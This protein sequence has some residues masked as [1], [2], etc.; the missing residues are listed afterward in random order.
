MQICPVTCGT[1]PDGGTDTTGNSDEGKE[2][3]VDYEVAF[4]S[5]A[6]RTEKLQDSE[7]RN[8]F[9]DSE[10]LTSVFKAKMREFGV[11]DD[12]KFEGATH[13]FDMSRLYTRGPS[14]EEEDDA[15][16]TED[17]SD[18]DALFSGG[19]FVGGIALGMSL[20]AIVGGF[21]W[22]KRSRGG[23]K[24]KSPK[25]KTKSS[26]N[27]FGLHG[28]E[29]E[30]T[31]ITISNKKT[32]NPAFGHSKKVVTTAKKKK[33]KSQKAKAQKPGTA[34]AGK[35]DLEVHTDAYGRRY[36]FNAKTNETKWLADDTSPS[37][38]NALSTSADAAKTQAAGEGKEKEKVEVLSDAQGRRYTY[39]HKSGESSWLND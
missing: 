36:T 7:V 9:T 28:G 16:A 20:C 13:D 22:M 11:S 18:A 21:V 2:C 15:D 17:T 30:L 27:S 19:T 23:I 31:E 39:N 1:C 34:N 14:E 6:D 4:Y 38:P 35:K 24:L 33:R 5:E 12:D 3:E 37:E 26:M 10:V 8:L 25:F 32:T 29:T